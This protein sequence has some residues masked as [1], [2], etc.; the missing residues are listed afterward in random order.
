MVTAEPTRPL[1]KAPEPGAAEVGLILP[2]LAEQAAPVATL[3]AEVA[4]AGLRSMPWPRALA[5]SAA[6]GWL[7]SFPMHSEEQNA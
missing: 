2:L 1:P 4:A 6:L 7:S 5:V 3:V